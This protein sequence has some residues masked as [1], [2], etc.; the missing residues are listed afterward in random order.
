[1]SPAPPALLLKYLVK[2]SG[3]NS[4][5]LGTIRKNLEQLVHKFSGPKS[6][7]G[8]GGMDLPTSVNPHPKLDTD[9]DLKADHILHLCVKPSFFTLNFDCLFLRPVCFG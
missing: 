5:F 4:N 7:W 3:T 9:N 6:E 8:A 2:G 1:M